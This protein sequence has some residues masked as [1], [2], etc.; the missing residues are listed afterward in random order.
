M[1][2]SAQRSSRV[3]NPGH[4]SELVHTSAVR[5]RVASLELMLDVESQRSLH[6]NSKG[7]SGELGQTSPGQRRVTT[8]SLQWSFAPWKKP[9]L[10]GVR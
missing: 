7:R 9:E 2:L 1:S 8:L 3:S 6:I 4:S 10:C 5:H